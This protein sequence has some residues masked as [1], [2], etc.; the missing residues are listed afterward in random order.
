ME[1]SELY[2]VKCLVQTD[3]FKTDDNIV[4]LTFDD[5]YIDQSINLMMSLVKNQTTGIS[6]VCAC[7]NLSD[8]NIAKLLKLGIGVKIYTYEMLKSMN[9]GRWSPNILLR[10]FSPW[11]F[12]DIDKL[13]YLDSDVLCIGNVGD[14]FDMDVDYVA[15]CNE[16]SGNISESR[17]AIYRNQYPT[18]IY[19]NSG[20]VVIN[21]E[22][23]RREY[24]L[25]EIFDSCCY[26]CE[27]YPYMDQDF[28]NVFFA[29][30][31][32]YINGF[33]YNFQAYE[34]LDSVLYK[35][36]LKQSRL[37]HFSCGKPWNYHTDRRLIK[38]YLNHSGYD[39]MINRM[40]KVLRKNCLLLPLVSIKKI[41]KK[42]KSFF[43]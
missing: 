9:T 4:M 30:K 10:L 41:V 35:K 5:G 28:L 24:A 2:S 6:F 21:T 1:I 19:C 20:V 15:M 36:A 32:N 34:L 11:L 17:E 40:K 27:H 25:Q 8:E 39:V 37:I 42:T 22:R 3:E 18:Q 23:I 33:R 7:L 14:L 26:S 13:L 16:I 43:S 12:E 38:L 29:G 31:I